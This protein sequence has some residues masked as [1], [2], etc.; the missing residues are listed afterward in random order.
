M[1]HQEYNFISLYL[2]YNRNVALIMERT[3]NENMHLKLDREN[4]TPSAPL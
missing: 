2:I 3:K 4:T 1:A